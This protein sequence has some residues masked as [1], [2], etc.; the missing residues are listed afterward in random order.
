MYKGHNP[1]GEKGEILACEFLKN[2][3]LKFIRQ[4]YSCRL[5]EIDL[6]FK[7]KKTLV[8]VEVKTRSSAMFGL[9]RESV[10]L[11]KQNKLRQIA[12]MFMMEHRC[13]PCACRFDVVEILGDKITH[14]KNAF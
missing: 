1:I 12:T 7:D 3:G 13:Y 11:H 2:Q 5:G 6:I 14:L 10:T 8:F 9:P 4:N